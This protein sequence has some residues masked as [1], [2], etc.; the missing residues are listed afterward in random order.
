MKPIVEQESPL[1]FISRLWNGFLGLVTLAWFALF[2]YITIKLAVQ[3]AW[4]MATISA[5]MT[6]VC[7]SIITKRV[8]AIRGRQDR[9]AR[10]EALLTLLSLLGIDGKE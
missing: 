3:N 7:G 6:A 4:G 10:S 1:E 9:T 8:S 2:A 5:V